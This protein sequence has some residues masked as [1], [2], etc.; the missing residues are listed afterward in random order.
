MRKCI[1]CANLVRTVEQLYK[2]GGAVQI[3]KIRWNNSEDQLELGKDAFSHL[4]SLPFS[5]NGV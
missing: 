5:P 1:I 2:A 3:N 4:L